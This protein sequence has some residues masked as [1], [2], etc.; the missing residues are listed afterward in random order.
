M[1]IAGV[2]TLSAFVNAQDCSELFISEYLEGSGNNKGIEIYNPTTQPIELA[3]GKTA[4]RV[5]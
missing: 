3:N 4:S 2:L 1:L 5:T